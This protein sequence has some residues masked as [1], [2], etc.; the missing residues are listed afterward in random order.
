MASALVAHAAH[1]EDGY[2]LWLRYRPEPVA[3]RRAEYARFTGG[4]VLPANGG[5]RPLLDSAR[6]EL[7]RA[8]TAITG[9]SPGARGRTPGAARGRILLGTP[10][11]G[12]VFQRLMPPAERARLGPEGFI[13]RP[14]AVGGGTC[15]VVDGG[16]DA[17]V[18]YG[19]FHLLEFLQ[20]GRPISELNLE[21]APRVALRIADH[22]DNPVVGEDGCSVE[23]GYAGASLFHWNELPGRVD[24]RL[25]D[26]ARLLAAM[27]VNGADVNNVNTDKRGLQGWRLLTSPWLPKL[28]ALATVL[29]P[30]GVR[31]Y[32]SVGFASPRLIGG[33][34]T[35]D[36]EDPRVA[37][38]WRDKA[39]EIYRAIP[40]F[41]GFV[42]KADSEDEPGPYR[43]GRTQ[44]Q[45]ANLI[46]AALAPHGGVMFWRAFVYTGSGDRAVDAYRDFRPLDGA[47]APN[48]ILQ[49]KNGPLDFQIREPVSSLLGAMPGTR[50]ALELEVT[51]EYTGQNREVCFLA[52]EWREVFAFD[53]HARGDGSTVARLVE[54]RLY[55]GRPGAVVG[56]MNLGSDRN[57]TGSLLAQANTYAFGRMAW[58]PSACPGEIADTWARLTFGRD[59]RAIAVITRILLASRKTFEDYTAPLGL[60]LL[61][62]RA[63]H[64]DPAPA[65]RV[66]YTHADAQGVGFDRTTATGSGYAGQ[67]FEPWRS[68]F[69]AVDTCPQN[70]LLFFHHVPY[71]Y[72]LP[73]GNTVIQEIYDRHDCGAAQAR[74]FVGWWRTIDGGID[75][76]RYASVLD[77]LEDQARIAEHWRAKING[78]FENLSGIPDARR[79][80]EP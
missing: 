68:R 15:L 21:D 64:F 10:D 51:Q 30:Y 52:S 22:W 6:A 63:N 31:L 78:Y 45:G 23:R 12:V 67:Y 14:A 2:E 61:S 54:G 24:P 60:G 36:P 48:V 73:S 59:P 69:E 11:D 75:A 4:I 46:A 33:L 3:A 66:N 7:I 72:R 70:L 65:A 58:D 13:V 40:D 50:Q 25:S 29:R 43:Y 44:A 19:T 38:W 74:R 55:P 41:G 26:Y 18:L 49:V 9:R 42:V 20:L 8:L 56:V 34:D 37:A 71:R 57:W 1:A 79:K 28:A 35:A 53:T 76:E 80:A 16:G 62:A 27:G 39:D 77:E 47:F 5:P 32:L 17:G